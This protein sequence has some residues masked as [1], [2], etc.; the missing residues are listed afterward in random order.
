M[1]AKLLQSLADENPDLQ[2]Q[3]GC[4]TGIFQLFD[5]H[6]ALT[7]RRI[8]QKRLPSGNSHFSYGSLERDSNNIHHRQTTTDTSSLNKGVNER[9][10][11]STESS[12]ASFS[13]CSSSVSSLDCKAE[14]EA[15]FDRIIF[16]ETPSRDAAMNQS[17]ISS[18]FGCNSLDLRDVVKDSMYREARGLSVKTTGKEESAMKHRDSPRPMQLPKSVDGSYRGGID[19]K[20]SVPI[21]LKESIRVL[22]KLREAPWYYAETK[23][24]PRSSHDVKDGPWHSN[25]KD[26]SW[27][28]NEGKEINRLSF[29]SRETI[30][31]TP[32]LKELP[33]LSLDSK[34]G[35]LR[36]Y[37]SDSATHPSRNIYSGTPTSNDKFSTLQQPSTIPRRPPGV[38]AKLMGL[39][40]LPD[41]SLAGD[42]QPCSTETYS[43]QDNSQFPRS[44]KQGLTRPL[45]V[46]HSPK[47]SL[48][49]PISPRRKNP[50]L[51]MKPISSS[52]FPIEPAP[53]KQQDG[54]RSSQKLNLRGVKAP[55][56]APDSFPS[57]YSEIEKRLK[58]LEFKQ[59]GRDLRALKQ[60]LEAMQEKGLL[61]SR[62]EE[63]APNVIGS[64]ND[65]DQRATIQDQNTRSLRQQNSQRNNFLP[66][67]IKGTESARAFES[68]IV[69]MKP[70]K[71]VEKTAIPAS[72]VIPIGG[73]SVSQKHQN[74]GVYL[75]NRTSTS[76][77]RVAKDQSPR[78]IHRDASASSIDK[79]ANGSKT[80]RSAQSQSRSQQ[81]LKENSQSSVKHSGTVSPRLQQKKLE[82]EKRSRPP[83]PPS[84][85]TKLRRQSGKKA[86]ESGSPGGKQRPKT[87]NSR[88]NDE[89]LSEISNES[90]SLSCLGDEISLQSDSLTVNSKM[91]VEVTS[92]LKSVEID[93]SQSPSLKAVKQ[94]ISETAPK[95][96]TPRLDEDESVAELGGDAPEHPSPISVLDGSVYRDDV[97]SPVKQISEDSKG[98]DAQESKEN[99]I[100][101]QWNPAESLSFHSMGSGEINRKKLQNIDHLVQKLRR[102]NSS[103][104]EARIDYIASLCENSNPDHRYI[105]E[106]L[107]ASGLLLRD[108]SSELLTFQLHSSGNPINPELFLV[109][110]QTKASSLLSKEESTPEKDSNMKLNKEKFHRKFIFDSVN[111]ILGAKLGSSLE[112][113]F[114]PNSNR[115]TKKTL[116]A[117]KLLKE[118]CF[119]IEKIQAKK[120]ECCLE[121]EDDDLKSMLCQDVMLGSESWTDFHGYLPGIVLDVERLI[122]KD[123]VDEVVIGESS[124]LRVKPSV[125]RRKLFGK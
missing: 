108:L 125:R 47:V 2:K 46:S 41:S 16:P 31:S 49:D 86:T 3:I 58:D 29:E 123:L 59:S 76:A 85:S 113:W 120:P 36:P 106:I 110:E 82:L 20:Q 121:D 99:E 69:I 28:G 93:D 124:G 97:P 55:A 119:E 1:A 14:G 52:R 61:E 25:A 19:G 65:Y 35:S 101:D 96:S 95:K 70:A 63:Q 17:T 111:E 5:R 98:D 80:T 40:A 74:A 23:E 102:L 18:H 60:I 26:A 38:V 83:A 44:S 53:W 122:F 11:I 94:L 88:H 114:L 33:R 37:S 24:L 27:F 30:K 42:T 115:L 87:L 68:P 4:M 105:S 51:V 54:N 66:S 39:E 43:A 50:D 100:K 8:A 15:P 73:L 64:Q 104:D 34:E 103:H 67:T 9:Q 78:N 107:L 89:Q 62:K 84:D 109:L 12:R 71:L 6:H 32:K 116:G 13:S 72:S 48:K 91:E 90:R 75:D 7:A 112:P 77:T 45:R 92:S 56:R 10:R 81:H 117:Q 79:K 22:A 57:V 21:D 118:L